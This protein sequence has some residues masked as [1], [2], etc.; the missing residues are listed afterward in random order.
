MGDRGRLV[1][2]VQAT[3]ANQDVDDLRRLS[4]RL[5]ALPQLAERTR[6]GATLERDLEGRANRRHG[7]READALN[8]TRRVT[9]RDDDADQVLVLVDERTS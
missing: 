7:D 4:A 6:E 1:E 3:E 8:A 5:R 9:A 2:Q